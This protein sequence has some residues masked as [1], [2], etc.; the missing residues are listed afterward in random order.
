MRRRVG[1]LVV[2]IVA[3]GAFAMGLYV[4]GALPGIRA[5]DAA[6]R[7]VIRTAT[8]VFSAFV[9]PLALWVA[10][11]SSLIS[12]AALRNQTAPLI[13]DVPRGCQDENKHTTITVG[14][15]ARKL[16]ASESRV[17]TRVAG[18]IATGFDLV[19]ALRNVGNGVA[20]V[21]SALFE[22][23]GKPVVGKPDRAIVTKEEAFR[24][25]FEVD[26][27]GGFQREVLDVGRM[28]PIEV[29]YFDASGLTVGL[30]TVHV[31]LDPPLETDQWEAVV[32]NVLV[33]ASK[34][35]TPLRHST[36]GLDRRWK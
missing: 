10:W 28:P 3:V 6:A 15:K 12:T 16:G 29:A 13:V 21:D 22:L 8:G 25:V 35:R 14:G 11:R 24:L 4:I 7:D 30:T 32:D 27:V 33:S 20:R 31:R 23:A 9:A 17:F 2:V 26:D 34:E 18:G 5:P 19:L 36:I 1:L